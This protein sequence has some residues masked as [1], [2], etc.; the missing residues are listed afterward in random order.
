[1]PTPTR[2]PT[3]CTVRRPTPRAVT[4]VELLVVIGIIAILISILLPALNRAREHAN[5]AKCSS[6]QRQIM[7]AF[8]MF[9]AEHRGH[10]PGN[11]WDGSQPDAEQRSWL[12]NYNESYE[13]APQGGTI[14]RYLKDYEVYKCPSFAD[15]IF[16]SGY[17]SNGR[18]DYASFLIFSGAKIT[19]VKPS[20]RFTYPGTGVVDTVPTP[21]VVEEEPQGGI[22][23][24]NVEGG[25]CESDRI[26]HIHFGGGYYASIDGSVHFF[27]EPLNANSHNWT[28]P[29]PSGTWIS[30]GIQARPGEPHIPTWNKWNGY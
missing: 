25:H 1:M 5:A 28:S 19:N 17:G 10:L 29:A 22:N 7:I 8:H 26:G 2:R 16:N 27:K 3:R 24:G 11:W 23:G 15:Q 20:S 4:L 14:F 18:F 6:N 21:V 13:M 30:L 12:R 9:A